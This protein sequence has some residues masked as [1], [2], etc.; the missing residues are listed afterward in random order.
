MVPVLHLKQVTDPRLRL[1]FLTPTQV[2]GCRQLEKSLYTHAPALLFL[3]NL[4]AIY[5]AFFPSLSICLCAPCLF[6]LLVEI[7]CTCDSGSELH[8]VT[9]TC[10]HTHKP[11]FFFSLIPYCGPC[12][13]FVIAP[14]PAH[15]ALGSRVCFARVC[16]SRWSIDCSVM[17]HRWLFQ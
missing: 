7:L 9:A 1:L 5:P 11:I 3:V 14:P 10:F 16:V 13:P 15:S 12:Q 8:T 6:F 4:C 2:P 17:M